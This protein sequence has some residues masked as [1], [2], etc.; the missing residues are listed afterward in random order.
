MALFETTI[1]LRPELAT[2]DVEKISD[3]FAQI[4]AENKGKVIKKEIWGI[5]DLAYKINK[6]KKGYFVHFGIEGTGVMIDELKRRLKIS[7][8]VIR[9]L[10]I[11]VK[12][13]ND[14]AKNFGD[15]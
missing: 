13:F 2:T 4:I 14:N 10:T 1:I 5:K 8:D 12:A 6:N 15:E 11:N 9:E 3:N 7:E